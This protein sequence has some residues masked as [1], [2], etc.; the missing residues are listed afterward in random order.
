[1]EGL[2]VILCNKA[3]VQVAKIV[4]D[5]APAGETSYDLYAVVFYIFGIDFFNCILMLSDNDRWGVDVE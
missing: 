1:M 3:E 5:R 4:I 2:T